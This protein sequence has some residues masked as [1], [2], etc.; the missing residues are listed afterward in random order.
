MKKQYQYQDY[1]NGCYQINGVNNN[2]QNPVAYPP[3][4]SYPGAMNPGYQPTPPGL[5][6]YSTQASPTMNQ[7]YPKSNVSW[8]E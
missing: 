5:F 3:P 1:P 2:Q 4:P 7:A 6:G 8:K